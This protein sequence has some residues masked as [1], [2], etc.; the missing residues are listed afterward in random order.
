MSQAKADKHAAKHSRSLAQ[1]SAERSAVPAAETRTD[2]SYDEIAQR[3]YHCWHERGCPDGS[4]EVDW[5]RA[6]EE[7][8][9]ERRASEE[10]H[11]KRKAQAVFPSI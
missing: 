3:A 9:S 8:R 5:T 6:E 7:L 10:L 4:P 2:P 1:Q 11:G